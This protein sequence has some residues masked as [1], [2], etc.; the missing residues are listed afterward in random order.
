[1]FRRRGCRGPPQH[2]QTSLRLELTSFQG[3]EHRRGPAI[4]P[5]PCPP[6][7]DRGLARS[8]QAP[9]LL[10]QRKNGPDYRVDAPSASVR[11][12]D[13]QPLQVS[14]CSPSRPDRFSQQPRCWPAFKAAQASSKRGARWVVDHHSLDAGDRRAGLR[15]SLNSVTRRCAKR[16]LQASVRDAQRAHS[17]RCPAGRRAG[18]VK[19]F[20]QTQ[21]PA[22][23]D[24]SGNAVVVQ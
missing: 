6:A 14:T 16:P 8:E 24:L 21:R 9:E 13:G 11:Q 19:P 17:V 20:R 18:K 7:R 2:A 4:K 1:M 22:T 23:R 15:K 3:L 5:S 10:E 12:L